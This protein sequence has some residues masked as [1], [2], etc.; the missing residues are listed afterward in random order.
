MSNLSLKL[1]IDGSATGALRALNEV[2]SGTTAVE[3][4]LKR[5]Q[6]V[7]RSALQFLGIGLGIRELITLADTYTNMT[8]RLKLVTQY[9]GNFKEVFDGLA[10]SARSTRSELAGT[11]DLYVK[12][13]PALQGI[14]LLGKPAVGIITTINQAIG[15]S[16][17]SAQSAAAAL[18]QLAQGIGAGALRGE[19]FNSVIEQTP[20]LAQAIADG[21]GVPIGAL[22]KLAE[23]GKLTA[24]AIADAL[25]K[26]APQVE[27]DF[28]KMPKTVG[29]A[30]VGLKNE[31]LLYVG[32]TDNAT[33][34]T[35]TLAAVIGEVA[36][37]FKDAGP[38]VTAFTEAV[39]VMVNGLDGAY[40]MLK[41]V[42]LGLAG[43]AVA[44]KLA[45]TGDFK[46]A[47]QVWQDLGKD[48]EDVLMKPLLTAPKLEEAAVDSAR[49]RGQLEEQLKTQV[50]KLEAQ[51]RYIATGEMD[52]IAGKEKETI[53]K[54]IA[55]QQRLVDAVHAAWQDSL[56]EATKASEAA[57]A[58]RDKAS[59]KRQSASDKATQI[60]N[61]DLSPEDKQALDLQTARDAQDQGAYAA[62]RA[63]VAQL[64]GRGKDFER[65]AKEAEKFLD[66]AMKFAESSG[67]ANLIEELGKQQASLLNTQA[68]GEDKKAADLN[69]Q[70][71][72]QATLL[73]DL[74]AKLEKMKAD[75][76]AIEVKV[77][78][79]DA[80]TKIKGFIK[81]LDAIP[82]SK[83]IT[84]NTVNA[85]GAAVP[86]VPDVTTARAFGGP[87]P[88]S[89][90][91]D[92]ADNML[93]W[94]TPGEWVIQ[95]PAARYYGAAFMAAINN[96]RLPKF[97]MGGQIGGSA[98]DRLSVPSLS[99]SARADSA[100]AGI[101]LDFGSLGKHDAM[102]PLSTQREIERVFKRAAL[103]FGRK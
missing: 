43:Y 40:R 65:Y 52:K 8:S 86:A 97:A 11:V 37:E 59:E 28:A 10:E 24:E 46:G 66:R 72:A 64:E 17:A 30:L 32:A 49:K 57:I 21:M 74:Q 101:T 54:R 71:A 67:D 73:N 85:G 60:R 12:I 94:G 23:D 25:R 19:E 102:A 84:V 31:V 76:R 13:A 29:Q 27:A 33:S 81:Q 68:K 88:G 96:M 55:E 47:R 9:A 91:H 63:G 5:L 6:D 36:K 62:A 98:I 89:A 61:K 41:I 69:A 18:T 93:Y 22:R 56:K 70:A 48:I 80:E 50:E 15:I 87:L 2:K 1:V 103:Q 34:G 100:L 38:V 99:P 26:V 35:S 3:N 4:Q 39:K 92:R 78:L 90:P 75:A 42:G 77:E 44:A 82:E 95:R 45:L 83:T 16:G 14:G 20:G 58:L 53:D 79:A 51:K 7:G